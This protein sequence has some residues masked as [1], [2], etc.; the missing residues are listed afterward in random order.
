MTAVTDEKGRFDFAEL[1]PGR[2]TLLAESP[3]LGRA[4]AS[5]ELLPDSPSEVRLV[6]ETALLHRDAITV[7]ATPLPTLTSEA[8]RPV[9]VLEDRALLGSLSTTLGETL[10]QQPGIT[11]NYSGPGASRPIIRG[12]SGDLIRILDHGLGLGDV[13]ASSPDHA[14]AFDPL[15][16]ERIEV[17]RG[18]AA[19]LYGATAVG[20]V[21]NLVDEAIPDHL[22]DH[23]VTGTVTL[24]AGSAAEER[25]GSLSLFGKVGSLAWTSSFAG[26]DAG[27][28]KIPGFAESD[29]LHKEH[30]PEEERMRGVLPNSFVESTTG[31]VGLSWVADQGFLGISALGFDS[32]Y[33][34]PGGGDD[35]VSIDL[36]LRRLDLRSE[37]TW[38]GPMERVKIRVGRYDYQHLEL[39]GEQIGTRFEADGLE[40]R[41]EFLHRPMGPFRGALGFQFGN[42][43][44]VALGEEAFLPTNRTEQFA[45]FVLEELP[46]G[47][48]T[49]EL[50]GRYERSVY[51]V[52]REELPDRSFSGVSGSVALRWK[53][54]ETLLTRIAISRTEVAPNPDSLY[55]NGFHDAV[56]RFEFG[57]PSLGK[58]TSLAL[59]A[60][61]RIDA[62]PFRLDLSVFL[63]RIDDFVLER[64]LEVGDEELPAIQYAA[65]DAEFRGFE[66]DSHWTLL[67]RHPHHLE[68][69]LSSDYVRAEERATGAALPRIPPL[70]YGL[71]LEYQG[72]R[73]FLT[74]GGKRVERP[75]R[76][77]PLETDT[78][79]YTWVDLT[80]GY[81]LPGRRSVHDLILIGRNLTDAEARVHSSFFKDFAPLP[82]RDLR[83]AYRF[84]F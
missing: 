47:S 60:G 45:L 31:R 7:T 74:L 18:P 9:A 41:L 65:S 82:G 48:L 46:V 30:A 22:P 37:W 25:S 55:A 10:N 83:L 38:K 50:G 1:P 58:E 19:L 36:K 76:L 81:R 84:S 11:S 4:L 42:R 17:V 28:V 3:Q 52:L 26:R 54:R 70:R 77:A 32:R 14:V 23:P 51:D 39:E 57:D 75:D 79:A 2:Y 16:A 5:V 21:V 6:L 64:I 61:L 49:L 29:L 66:V 27:D 69:H 63:N 78:P 33:G 24:L 13:S 72:E 80:V 8:N 35:P 43:D 20:G 40:G 71:A 62:E 67:H 34:I 12:L 56:Q 59:D 53:P 15:S 44:Y 68:L 73:W